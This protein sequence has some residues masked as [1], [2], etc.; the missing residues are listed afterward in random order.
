MSGQDTGDIWHGLNKLI[1]PGVVN[2]EMVTREYQF[3]ADNELNGITLYS[4]NSVGTKTMTALPANT[5]AVKLFLWIVR[6]GAVPFAGFQRQSTDTQVFYVQGTGNSG[7]FLITQ[8]LP[9]N[10][11]QIYVSALG[12]SFS[13]VKIVSYKVKE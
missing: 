10:G 4:F 12:S 7:P 11:N 5:I 8:W 1:K 3:T 6:A 9:T 2:T 13:E